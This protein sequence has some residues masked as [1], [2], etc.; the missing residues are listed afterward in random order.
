[1][2][3]KLVS[4]LLMGMMTVGMST[5]AFAAETSDSSEK[6]VNIGD[7]LQRVKGNIKEA[8]NNLDF[9][10]TYKTLFD[11]ETVISAPLPDEGVNYIVPDGKADADGKANTTI[12]QT[13]F[14][15]LQKIYNFSSRDV[16]LPVKDDT[17]RKDYYTFLGWLYDDVSVKTLTPEEIE[18]ARTMN[19]ATTNNDGTTNAMNADDPDWQSK[20]ADEVPEISKS[21][22]SDTGNVSFGDTNTK[23]NKDELTPSVVPTKDTG[24]NG[25]NVHDEMV[26]GN[27]SVGSRHYTAYWR[28]NVLKVKLNGGYAEEGNKKV[29]ATFGKGGRY[30]P[31]NGHACYVDGSAVTTDNGY[32]IAADGTITNTALD[33]SVN[34]ADIITVEEVNPSIL[35]ANYLGEDADVGFNLYLEDYHLVPGK[36]W[37]DNE[38]NY[39]SQADITGHIFDL[40]AVS[41]SETS[42]INKQNILMDALKNGDATLELTANWEPNDYVITYDVGGEINPNISN[43][44][45]V[46]P[47]WNSS[48]ANANKILKS[49]TDEGKTGGTMSV[50][51]SFNKWKSEQTVT[52][53]AINAGNLPTPSRAYYEFDGWFIKDAAGVD[54]IKDTDNDGKITN[55][56]KVETYAQI[57]KYTIHDNRDLELV[58]EWIPYT[59]QLSYKVGDIA[60]EF[61]NEGVST[62]GYIK[63]GDGTKVE[64][65]ST[66]KK[67]HLTEKSGLDE[68]FSGKTVPAF[69]IAINAEAKGILAVTETDHFNKTNTWVFEPKGYKRSINTYQH[70]LD[71][72]KDYDNGEKIELLYDRKIE[73]NLTEYSIVYNFGTAKFTSLNKD[74]SSGYT[75]NEKL[76]GVYWAGGTNSFSAASYRKANVTLENTGVY[77]TNKFE[78]VSQSGSDVNYGK[79]DA[80][81]FTLANYNDNLPKALLNCHTMTSWQENG[82]NKQ[83]T[84]YSDFVIPAQG[85]QTYNVTAQWSG[86]SHKTDTGKGTHASSNCTLKGISY[87]YC[88]T[89]GDVSS[90][91]DIT[92]LGHKYGSWQYNTSISC[93]TAGSKYRVCA[94]DASHIEKAIRGE[95]IGQSVKHNHSDACYGIESSWHNNKLRE[96]TTNKKGS[97]AAARDEMQSLAKTY[98]KNTWGTSHFLYSLATQISGNSSNNDNR[99]GYTLLRFYSPTYTDE[100]GIWRVYVTVHKYSNTSAGG[101][102]F[103]VMLR[104]KTCGY[105]NGQH[106]YYKCSVC[107]TTY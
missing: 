44:E 3:R 87:T 107:G 28:Q 5:T 72:V 99:N 56:D 15:R 31:I 63:D 12:P 103:N 59:Y 25:S 79:T 93:K 2:K 89:C 23:L 102:S 76:N 4:L 43:K 73:S 96:A 10:V 85:S 30:E 24:E 70:L 77:T 20:L 66:V 86:V 47:V 22:D 97:A 55:G 51:G 106:L 82:T 9:I 41:Y 49:A 98:A 17:F 75:V 37:K 64:S 6:N 40:D 104:P 91:G 54:G 16:A 45:N 42:E 35:D 57:I 34:I 101:E 68:T 80:I 38:G 29:Y 92:A 71:L 53:K 21:Y 8:K 74:Y 36:E 14:D 18:K 13:S 65:L 27:G 69:V 11:D 48:E 26:I 67:L 88:T 50:G 52:I 95:H 81:K 19:K 32:A 1:M 84:K 90:T 7:T 78:P 46:K 60:D 39:Y 94:N 62:D 83:I 100:S 61:Y 33:N 105:T 58:A